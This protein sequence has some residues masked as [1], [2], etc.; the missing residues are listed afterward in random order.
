MNHGSSGG[1]QFGKDRDSSL[2]WFYEDLPSRTNTKKDV[3][4]IIGD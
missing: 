4:L 2:N 3:L 1:E